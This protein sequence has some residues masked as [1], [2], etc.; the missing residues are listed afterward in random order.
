LDYWATSRAENANAIIVRYLSGEVVSLA[1]I[2]ITVTRAYQGKSRGTA[3]AVGRQFR[4]IYLIESEY[5]LKPQ[6]P[7]L[8]WIDDHLSVSV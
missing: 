8:R 5:G 4:L 2:R 6:T 1:D 3:M 7:I